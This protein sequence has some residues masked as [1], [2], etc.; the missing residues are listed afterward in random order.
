MKCL[1]ALRRLIKSKEKG[2]FMGS[3]F[4]FEEQRE[5]SAIKTEIVTKYFNAWASILSK[6]YYKIA[7]IDLFAGPGIYEDGSKSTPIIITENVLQNRTYAQKTVLYFNEKN[8]EYYYR[9]MENINSIHGI[10]TLRHKPVFNNLEV[11]YDTPKD[12]MCPKIPSFCFFDPAGYKGL[13]LDLIY[14]FGK[15]SGT[16]IIFFFNYNDINRAIT[17]PKVTSDMI[18][19]FGEQHYKSLLQN[20]QGQSG[21]N[22]ESIVVNEMAEAIKDKGIKYILPFRFKFSGKERTSHYIIFASKNSIGFSIMKDIMY[23]IGEK[24][25]HGIGK[26]EFIPSCDK[27]NYLQLGIIDFYNTPFEEFKKYLCQK[28][29]DK[30]ITV[31]DL[32]KS[33]I[34]NT[35]FIKSQY[36][37]ALIQLETEGLI[38]CLPQNHK[39][40]TMGDNVELIFP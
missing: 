11:D 37:K 29:S 21:Q 38:T 31:I 18:H 25:F 28:Y 2:E 40:G 10:S 22:R 6:R 8:T 4:D 15:D 35:K 12:F 39:K 19:L 14:S 16:D 32:I 5:Q 9:L 27:T 1:E 26:F 3:N 30:R 20:I 36:K 13:S 7:Y 33:D 24:D 23:K 34:P 17:N